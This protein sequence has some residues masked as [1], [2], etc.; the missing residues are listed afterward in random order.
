MLSRLIYVSR[1]KKECTSAEI[2]KILQSCQKNNPSHNITGVLLYSPTQFIQYLEGEYKEIIGLYDRIK[3]DQRHSDTVMISTGII[4]EKIFPGWHMGA[5]DL[6][7]A[8]IDYRTDI[9]DE[10]RK[11]FNSLLSGTDQNGDR[12]ISVIRKIFN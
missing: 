2:D 10:D 5:K 7:G 11:V 6:A 8:N 3:T 4:K 9:S 1:R 12:V